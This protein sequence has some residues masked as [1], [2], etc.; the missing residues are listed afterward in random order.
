MYTPAGVCCRFYSEEMG[1]AFVVLLFD[2]QLR[3]VIRYPV[4]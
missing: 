3:V 2:G 1:G 4:E